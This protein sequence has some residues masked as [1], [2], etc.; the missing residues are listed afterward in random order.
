MQLFRVWGFLLMVF[1]VSQAL[2]VRADMTF[3]NPT[4]DTDKNTKTPTSAV[5]TKSTNSGAV[6]PANTQIIYNTVI[7]TAP[8]QTCAPTT[9]N[10]CRVNVY[11]PN[12]SLMGTTQIVPLPAPYGGQ[13]VTVQ[14]INNG[15]Y[16]GY[17]LLDAAKISCDLP[18]CPAGSIS[19]CGVSVPVPAGGVLGE[20]NT[21][22]VPSALLGDSSGYESVSF[23]AQCVEGAGGT[24]P[25]YQLVDIEKV[26]CNLFPCAEQKVRLCNQDIVVEGGAHLGEVL[27]KIM[28]KSFVPDPYDVMCLG[29][30]GQQPRYQITDQ[31]AVTCS[32]TP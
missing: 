20:K 31:S 9:L 5:S 17:Q 32:K 1:V 24:T 25:G 14:C 27:H 23:T 4:P 2:P 12:S 30:M 28:P 29:T 11:I 13:T 22:S 18:H 21:F 16:T 19:L 8:N 15:S 10:L 3:Y 7:A 26:S 6:P